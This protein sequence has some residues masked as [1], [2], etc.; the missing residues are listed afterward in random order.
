MQNQWL[1]DIELVSD[2]ITLIPLR[3]D[4]ANALVTAASDGDLWQL[5]F[6]GVPNTDTID[7]YIAYAL[8]EKAD[9]RS[10]PFV[11]VHNETGEIIGSTRFCNADTKNR[12][13]EIGYT[14]YAKRYQQSS[15]NTECKRL[16]LGH[17]FESLDAIAI[18]FRTHWH[19]QASRQA[20]ARLGAKQDGVLRNHQVMPDGSYRD[21]VVFSIINIEW[22]AVKQNLAYRLAR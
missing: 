4:H 16:L 7:T 6:T 22:P 18:E 2:T 19:N 12:R 17:A 13:V 10:L 5:W 20:I 9:G 3:A 21:T 11:V 14:W 15:V 8:E 1:Y